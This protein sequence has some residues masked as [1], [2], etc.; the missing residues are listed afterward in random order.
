[1]TTGNYLVATLDCN[2]F[3]NIVYYC[4]SVTVCTLYYM[5]AK[6]FGRYTI[7]CVVIYI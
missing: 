1:M 5:Y 6:E 3:N 4:V 7:M 2:T